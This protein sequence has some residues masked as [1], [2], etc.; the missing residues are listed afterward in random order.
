MSWPA[1]FPNNCPP[2]D[3]VEP[4]HRVYRFVGNNPPTQLDF[5]SHKERFSSRNFGEKECEACGLSVYTDLDDAKLARRN[6][7]G[8]AKKMLA[9]CDLRSDDGRIKPTP[10]ISGQ[11][12]HTWWKA[13]TFVAEN[14]FSIV[15][16]DNLKND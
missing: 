5:L 4:N 14:Q 7:P 3:A 10:S 1:H 9:Q 2:D 6:V 12:H 16:N 15:T 13:P 11:S 8:M